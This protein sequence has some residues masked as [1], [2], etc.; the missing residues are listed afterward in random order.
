MIGPFAQ[1][2]LT[3][4]GPDIWVAD[5][6]SIRFYGMPFPTRMVVIRRA[7]GIWVH[8]P[9]APAPAVLDQVA[10]L[11]PVTDLIAPNWIHY[12]GI[13][14]WQEAFP[15]ARAW[16]APGVRA[17][18]KSR[19][20]Q[21]RWH[22]DLDQAAWGP[23][24]AQRIVTGS[25]AHTE[26]VFFHRPSRVLILTDLIENMQARILPFWL[27][28]LARLGGIVA[29]K[30]RMPLDMWMSFAGGRA[31]L[32]DSVNWMLAQDPAQVIVAHGLCFDTDIQARLRAGFR[33]VADAP[34]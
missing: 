25:R 16:A 33:G 1:D 11:G 29:P 18:A 10:A 26:A 28:P 3:A 27:R 20:V 7:D 21:I 8:S 31:A 19:N 6:P 4:L 9:V 34:G 23:D 2:R 15:D 17:R 5:G 32:R 30:G 12:A 22:A 14:A 24:L 13:P